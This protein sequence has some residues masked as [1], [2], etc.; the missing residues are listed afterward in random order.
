MGIKRVY[1]IPNY[2]YKLLGEKTKILIQIEED[3]IDFLTLQ[4][5][6]NNV[7]PGEMFDIIQIKK[8]MTN[9]TGNNYDDKKHRVSLEELSL[10]VDEITDICFFIIVNDGKNY[11][12]FL[13]YNRKEFNDLTKIIPFY[14]NNQ[15]GLCN[16]LL[17]NEYC[18]TLNEISGN[19]R[20]KE[21][22]DDLLEVT[23]NI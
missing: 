23:E 10:I 12:V 8:I 2:V 18:F 11:K 17:E 7:L 13:Q 21:K 14:I 6:L 5:A 20:L 15:E 3:D 4:R 19:K 16:V 1:L 22:L 9:I